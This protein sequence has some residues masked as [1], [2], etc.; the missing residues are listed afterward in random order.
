MCNF[1]VAIVDHDCIFRLLQSNHNQAVYLKYIKEIILHKWWMK[2][3]SY[4]NY[5]VYWYMSTHRKAFKNIKTFNT[6]KIILCN[7]KGI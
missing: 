2:S 7:V 4:K 5:Y 6:L 3:M 1:N